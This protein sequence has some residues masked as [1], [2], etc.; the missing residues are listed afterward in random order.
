[1][2]REASENPFELQ[3]SD[4]PIERVHEFAHDL[5]WGAVNGSWD[6]R[7]VVDRYEHWSHDPKTIIEGR[8]SYTSDEA[9][10]SAKW[11]HECPSFSLLLS[12]GYIEKI[13]ERGEK[14]TSSDPFF[15]ETASYI[16]AS[17]EIEYVLTPL[18]FSL[19][20]KPTIPSRVF[21]S[22]KRNESSALG[23][24]IEARLKLVDKNIGV[25]ID[26]LL[27]PGDKWHAQLEEKVRQSRYFICL[28]SLRTL[29]SEFVRNEIIWA[30]DEAEKSDTIIIPVCHNGYSFDV[31]LHEELQKDTGV[32]TPLVERLKIHNAITIYPE[33][34]EEYELAIIK[35]LNKL[36]YSTI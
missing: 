18:A 17:F 9:E 36:G 15:R 3:P 32:I 2:Q 34:A 16:P 30:L 8:E 23:L 6:S 19:L 12:F 13:G 5:A 24:L 22:Y 21:I 29:G 1:M 27:E 35:I 10:F 33:S 31:K 25:F 11:R 26:K 7:I 4:D 14:W 28:L 20:H